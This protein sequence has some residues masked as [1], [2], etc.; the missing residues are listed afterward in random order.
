VTHIHPLV[1]HWVPTVVYCTYCSSVL[2]SN[3]KLEIKLEICQ[4]VRLQR[5]SN[6]PSVCCSGRE[7]YYRYYTAR[8]MNDY[9]QPTAMAS[10]HA[11]L[12]CVS[13]CRLGVVL[14]LSRVLPGDQFYSSAD[15]AVNCRPTTTLP[16]QLLLQRIATSF[17][18][19]NISVLG[20]VP[21]HTL[22]TLNY[23]SLVR[24]RHCDT[25]RQF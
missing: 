24:W 4:P 20:C 5:V 2:N 3:T 6:R 18:Q 22:L 7:D 14:T 23:F 19:L 17:L 21:T 8:P 11:R 10:R 25:L 12:R 13:H 9:Y 1:C 15:T 16:P